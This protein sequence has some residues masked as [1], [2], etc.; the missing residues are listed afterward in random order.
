[1]MNLKN[2]ILGLF[3]LESDDNDSYVSLENAETLRALT[4]E[5]EIVR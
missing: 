5:K 2:R 4:P 3:G 1:M